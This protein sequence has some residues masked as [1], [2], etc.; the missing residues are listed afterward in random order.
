[1]AKK[2]TEVKI[3]LVDMLQRLKTLR[4][5]KN[6]KEE[7]LAEELGIDAET[8]AD[9][10]KGDIQFSLKEW[11]VMSNIMNVRLFYFLTGNS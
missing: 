7:H 3:E 5:D 8:Y 4:K 2:K 10:E 11:L 9:K 1:M 6:I